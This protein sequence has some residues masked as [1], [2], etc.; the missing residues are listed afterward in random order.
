MTDA[1][2]MMPGQDPNSPYGVHTT[3][4]SEA[5]YA[6]YTPGYEPPP[7]PQF[8][9]RPSLI[10]RVAGALS[11]FHMD[12]AYEGFFDPAQAN[13]L[14]S[15][16]Q[17]G[18][19]A[20]LLKAGGPAPQG[21][22]NVASRIGGALSESTANW[23]QVQASAAQRNYQLWQAQLYMSQFQRA[24]QAFQSVP[25]QPG[26]EGQG[27]LSRYLKLISV[28]GPGLEMAK[29]I[30]PIVKAMTGMDPTMWDLKEVYN[31][32]T[33]QREFSGVNKVTGQP[34]P[35][36]S[37]VG[38]PAGAKAQPGDVA[39]QAFTN[40]QGVYKDYSGAVKD[41]RDRLQQ[42]RGALS[43]ADKLATSQGPAQAVFLRQFVNSIRMS[44]ARPGEADFDLIKE[45]ASVADRLEAKMRGW[46]GK[47]QLLSP[48]ETKEMVNLAHRLYGGI[49]H[50]WQQL[51][52][53][54]R[55]LIRRAPDYRPGDEEVIQ[56]PE[57]EPEPQTG[58]TPATAP[59]KPKFS[60]APGVP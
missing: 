49:A 50:T 52:L 28:G 48:S 3:D 4:P 34:F 42:A 41:Y 44:G 36:L 30:E 45:S 10:S 23:P 1:P 54:H 13:Y 46:T 9:K 25:L 8:A 51:A 35:G 55:M 43:I 26:Q 16:A 59:T 38:G 21:T 6:Q 5:Q 40:V 56:G 57:T 11:P 39:Q 17:G 33:K 47:G 29:A 12:P 20:A 18:L 14:K 37:A 60:G 31:P 7:P 27:M 15:Q 22:Q 24:Q 58:A 2:L 53:E 32:K 19:A